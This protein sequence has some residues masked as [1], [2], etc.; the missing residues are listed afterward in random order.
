MLA[1]RATALVVRPQ[2]FRTVA[3]VHFFVIGSLEENEL[4]L[5]SVLTTYIETISLILKYAPHPTRRSV[6]RVHTMRRLSSKPPNYRNQVD[7]R[8]LSENFDFLLLAMDELV[9]DGYESSDALKINRV[10]FC[11]SEVGHRQ[12]NN[13]ES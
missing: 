3:D 5:W 4:V 8:T 11:S 9:D 7:K 10:V 13:V 1:N 12:S 2:V 6:R